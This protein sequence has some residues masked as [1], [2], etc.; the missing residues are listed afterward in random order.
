MGQVLFSGLGWIS[1]VVGRRHR[2]LVVDHQIRSNRLLC[3]LKV[4]LAVLLHWLIHHQLLLF[5]II[6]TLLNF[7]CSILGHL[8]IGY[9][10]IIWNCH[11]A[12]RDASKSIVQVATLFARWVTQIKW[13]LQLR[14]QIFND[15][16][17]DESGARFQFF[18][19]VLALFEHA[20]LI[21]WLLFSLKAMELKKLCWWIDTL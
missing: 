1:Y 4:R 19:I 10:V 20:V 21:L 7:I 5:F 18:L 6:E 13:L 8:F 3:S 15:S 11:F 12:W 16:L 2:S 17:A 9:R 14:A